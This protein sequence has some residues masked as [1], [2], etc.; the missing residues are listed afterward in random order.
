MAVL[1]DSIVNGDLIVTG[2]IEGYLKKGDIGTVIKYAGTVDRDYK[3]PDDSNSGTEEDTNTYL[4]ENMGN[5]DIGCVYIVRNI[6][7]Y[8]PKTRKYHYDPWNGEVIWSYLDD[9]SG[10]MGWEDLGNTN[11]LAGYYSRSETDNLLDTKIPKDTFTA[12]GQLLYSNGSSSPIALDIGTNDYVL[13][14]SSGSPAW[15]EKAPKATVSDKLGTSAG[16]STTP[17]YFSDGVPASCSVSASA[18]E[19]KSKVIV[20]S[21][22][23]C[24]EMGSEIKLNYSNSGYVSLESKS[25]LVNISGTNYPG[26][27]CDQH[28]QATK[29][30]NAVWNDLADAIEVDDDCKL[31][32]GFCYSFDGINYTKTSKKADPHFIGIHSDT[33]GMILGLKGRKELNVAVAGFVLAYT[34][35]I[36]EPGTPLMAG[37]NGY[38]TKAGFFTRVLHPERVVATFW[39]VEDSEYWGDKDNKV[40]VNNRN[41]VKIK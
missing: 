16:N 5:E 20:T 14:V 37:E 11:A 17:V 2:K 18:D 27:L 39:K 23:G 10:N 4:P 22:A 36:Y 21:P 30:Y 31:E 35:S 24:A 3:I 25:D 40:K 9:T 38:L 19:N 34:D 15:V 12:A 28:F 33:A 26:I 41:W 8:D 13:S 1:K 6:R 7:V 32:P 29:V